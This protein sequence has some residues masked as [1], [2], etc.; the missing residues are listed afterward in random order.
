MFHL[1]YMDVYL[2]LPISKIIHIYIQI[3]DWFFYMYMLIIFKIC[4]LKQTSIFKIGRC[5]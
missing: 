3:K 2:N 5:G 4:R 1:P